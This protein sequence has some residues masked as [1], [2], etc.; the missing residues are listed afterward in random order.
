MILVAKRHLFTAMEIHGPLVHVAR[1]CPLADN[2]VASVAPS[3]GGEGGH[4]F[5]RQAG[6]RLADSARAPTE[7]ASPLVRSP[8]GGTPP[9]IPPFK[10]HPLHAT[11]AAPSLQAES[12]WAIGFMAERVGFEP[13]VP[14]PAHVLSRHAESAALA[15]LHTFPFQRRGI[16]ARSLFSG[17]TGA[18]RS[19]R[20]A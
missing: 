12:F 1:P 14:L 3:S 2:P 4:L 11:I 18:P 10:S 16:L 15:P 5:T 17:K 9:A 20:P 7:G 13:T 8:R 19:E 6:T